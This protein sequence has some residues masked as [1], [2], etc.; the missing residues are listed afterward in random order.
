MAAQNSPFQSSINTD[1]F[2]A[3]RADN[4][5]QTNLPVHGGVAEP[6]G[7][8]ASATGKSYHTDES[9]IAYCFDRD[10]GGRDMSDRLY[11]AT[12]N[13]VLPRQEGGNTP[14]VP[15][16]EGSDVVEDLDNYMAR[17]TNAEMMDD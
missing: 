9:Y 16:E 15:P 1:R 5:S 11:A 14:P 6:A 8:D 7:W 13:S 17:T 4:A 12:R 2:A 3:D 10:R